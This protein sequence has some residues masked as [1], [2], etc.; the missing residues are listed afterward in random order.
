[1]ATKKER[2]GLWNPEVKEYIISSVDYLQWSMKWISKL[3]YIKSVPTGQKTLWQDGK[4]YPV[5]EDRVFEVWANNPTE[6]S[7]VWLKLRFTIEITD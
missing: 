5:F 4:E 1:M 2:L 7:L 3:K 6:E